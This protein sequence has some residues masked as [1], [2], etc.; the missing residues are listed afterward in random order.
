MVV[1][2]RRWDNHA[3][4]AGEFLATVSMPMVEVA[5]VATVAHRDSVIHD[6]VE[7]TLARLDE[8]F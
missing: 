5:V 8:L 1:S 6:H 3:L 7:S 2:S 4:L